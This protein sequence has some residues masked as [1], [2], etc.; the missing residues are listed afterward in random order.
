MGVRQ[1]GPRR[2]PAPIQIGDRILAPISGLVRVFPLSFRP[3]PRG[4]TAPP[5]KCQ[6]QSAARLLSH[7]LAGRRTSFLRF[8]EERTRCQCSKAKTSKTVTISMQPSN[9]WRKR[10]RPV[11]ARILQDVLLPTGLSSGSRRRVI[12]RPLETAFRR[13]WCTAEQKMSGDRFT[14]H[15]LQSGAI[16]YA[17]A[18]M[19]F[20]DGTRNNL[21]SLEQRHYHKTQFQKAYRAIDRRFRKGFAEWVVKSEIADCS[22]CELGRQY[23]LLNH[24]ESIKAVSI[25]VLGLC[26]SDLSA[27]F[28]YT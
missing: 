23:C 13:G 9:A 2:A 4:C 25:F 6:P 14:T 8:V 16:Q 19:Y 11:W 27:H 10:A 18:R 24:K 3:W 22:I 7:W 21:N 28:G 20:I 12:E 26:L 15:M 1:H 5:R 17:K